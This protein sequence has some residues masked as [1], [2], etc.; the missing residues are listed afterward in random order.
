MFSMYGRGRVDRGSISLCS[1][2]HPSFVSSRRRII[3]LILKVGTIGHGGKFH[4]YSIEVIKI[5]M[6][7]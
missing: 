2:S 4:V 1:L 7:Y 3:L 6:N 5:D